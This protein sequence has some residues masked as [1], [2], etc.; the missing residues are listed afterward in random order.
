M[1]KFLNVSFPE[2][3]VWGGHLAPKLR[4]GVVYSC[5]FF[6]GLGQRVEAYPSAVERPSAREDLCRRL[7]PHQLSLKLEHG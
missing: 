6:C 3:R 4:A 5:R 2:S 1:T 7:R